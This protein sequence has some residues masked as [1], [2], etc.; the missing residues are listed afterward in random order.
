MKLPSGLVVKDSKITKYLL[1]YQPKDDK[2]EYLSYYGYSLAN[3]ESLKNDILEAA[4]KSEITENFVTDWGI[5]YKVKCQWLSPN[6]RLLKVITIW[7][8]DQTTA[9]IKFVTLYPDKE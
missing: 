8:E 4:E 9:R 7:Q 3:W 6:N 2:S 1:V 5:R